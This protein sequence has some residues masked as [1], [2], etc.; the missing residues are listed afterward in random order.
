M[1]GND[2]GRSLGMPNIYQRL[3]APGLLVLID[4]VTH[5][6][7]HRME[8]GIRPMGERNHQKLKCRPPKRCAKSAIYTSSQ[9]QNNCTNDGGQS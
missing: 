6:F 4:Y 2:E 9:S 8:A 7:P 3:R 1:L 5:D